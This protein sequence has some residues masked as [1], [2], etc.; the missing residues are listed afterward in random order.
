MPIYADDMRLLAG[1]GY[2]EVSNKRSRKNMPGSWMHD[3]SLV[4]T[5]FLVLAAALIRILRRGN[6]EV[7]QFSL[8]LSKV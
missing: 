4:A 2:R 5:R 1:I 3:R 8:R 6:R 7:G